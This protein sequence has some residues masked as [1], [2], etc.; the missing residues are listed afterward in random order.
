[1]YDNARFGMPEGHMEGVVS[2]LLDR[3]CTNT[4]VAHLAGAKRLEELA[5]VMKWDWPWIP[6]D[7]PVCGV[8]RLLAYVDWLAYHEN[9]DKNSVRQTLSNT[10]SYFLQNMMI[11]FNSTEPGPWFPKGLLHPLL[12]LALK[13][14]PVKEDKVKRQAVPK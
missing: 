8:Y 12:T 7:D 13:H 9:L 14:L 3:G 2:R 1:M 5:A 11:W 4:A 6:L 10:K